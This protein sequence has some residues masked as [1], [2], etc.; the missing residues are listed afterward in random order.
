MTS[1]FKYISKG[2][3]HPFI[4]FISPI[5]IDWF[6]DIAVNQ[7]VHSLSKV[8]VDPKYFFLKEESWFKIKFSMKDTKLIITCD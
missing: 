3:I 6:L 5:I 8:T 4:I 2:K 7:R 1:F